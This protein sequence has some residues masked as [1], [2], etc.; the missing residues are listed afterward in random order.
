[1]YRLIVGTIG[2]L[3][4][5]LLD[6]LTQFFSPDYR[7]L[8][9][10]N[11]AVHILFDFGESLSYYSGLRDLVPSGLMPLFYDRRFGFSTVSHWPLQLDPLE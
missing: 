3:L 6:E 4:S 10:A 5:R 1:L 7:F 9:Y 11:F 8:K 2:L